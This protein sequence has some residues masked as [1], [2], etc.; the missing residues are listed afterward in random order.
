MAARCWTGPS[1]WNQKHWISSVET[2]WSLQWFMSSFK[3][4]DLKGKSTVHFKILLYLWTCFTDW[5]TWC[6]L[7][8][9]IL[10]SP[11]RHRP[12]SRAIR[13][14]ASLQ[15][16]AL[17]SGFS[18][19]FRRM[20]LYPGQ[21]CPSIFLYISNNGREEEDLLWSYNVLEIEIYSCQPSQWC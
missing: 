2:S 11:Q 13:K 15:T 18:L 8:C 3:V 6:S 14:P 12:S 4:C 19:F 16:W 9:N 21:L 20:L 17:S 5:P 7:A 1:V 10:S